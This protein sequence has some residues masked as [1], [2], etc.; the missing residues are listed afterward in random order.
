MMSHDF[1]QLLEVLVFLCVFFNCSLVQ[2]E[3]VRYRQQW[4]PLAVENFCLGDH[5]ETPSLSLGDL[6]TVELD[7]VKM[8]PGREVFNWK[9]RGCHFMDE[10]LRSV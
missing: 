5:T 2:H 6:G 4:P 8:S 3:A 7:I 10:M 1:H 9:S